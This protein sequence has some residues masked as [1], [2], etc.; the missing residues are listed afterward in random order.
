MEGIMLNSAFCDICLILV[1]QDLIPFEI[2]RSLDQF[3]KLQHKSGMCLAIN[4]KILN[5]NM[6]LRLKN[7]IIFKKCCSVLFS[8]IIII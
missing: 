2:S 3:G 7:A 4:H 1:T 5:Q 6:I 8:Y